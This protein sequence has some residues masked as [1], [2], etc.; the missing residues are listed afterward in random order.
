M[1]ASSRAVALSSSRAPRRVSPNMMPIGVP[2][3]GVA[4]CVGAA[5]GLGD[6]VEAPAPAVPA[7]S[8][9]LSRAPPQ[10]ESAMAVSSA[11]MSVWRARLGGGRPRLR[12]GRP[13]TEC[14]LVFTAEGSA[15]GVAAI[16]GQCDADDQARARA[17]QPQDGGG[18]LVAAAEP[19]DRLVCDGV[20]NG[21]LA[22][23]DH[24]GDHRSLDRAGAYG[25]DTDAARR[26]LERGALGHSEDAVLGGVVGGASRVADEAAER[27]AVD[28]GATSLFAHLA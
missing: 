14:E 21:E 12:R 1:P 7:A 22:I 13:M 20:V 11:G 4:S 5:L 16:D 26:V 28:D 18:D 9:P 27:R 17:A 10:A 25:V 3:S 8:S 2:A 24:G 19:S 23:R 6:G 15:G